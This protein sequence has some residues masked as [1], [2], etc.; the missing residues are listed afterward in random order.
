MTQLQDAL[1]VRTGRYRGFFCGTDLGKLAAPPE[2]RATCRTVTAAIRET[3][4]AEIPAEVESLPR[5]TGEA[6]LPLNATAAVWECLAERSWREGEL[7]L[8]P[9]IPG[10]G[11]PLRFPLARL[12]PRWELVPGPASAHVLYL[13]LRLRA[14]SAGKLFYLA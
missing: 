12:E 1:A 9:E 3:G 4:N 10:N 2:I 14:D 7:R 8:Q 13:H 11:T 5:L 6:V